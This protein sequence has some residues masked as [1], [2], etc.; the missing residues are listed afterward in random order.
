[1]RLLVGL[2]IL[3]VCGQA[4]AGPAERSFPQTTATEPVVERD[5]GLRLPDPE[6]PRLRLSAQN[7]PTWQDTGAS[8]VSQTSTP[9]RLGPVRF[10]SGRGADGRQHFA[11]YTLDGVNVFGSEVS[12]TIDGGGAKVFL[13]WHP[14]SE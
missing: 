1:M 5:S 9:L 8:D 10:E 7:I 4:L 12:G 11:N 13:R 6:V 2:A 14:D 3:A